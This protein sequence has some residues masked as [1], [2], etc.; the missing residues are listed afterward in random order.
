MIELSTPRRAVHPHGSANCVHN[1]LVHSYRKKMTRTTTERA[2]LQLRRSPSTYPS[3]TRG[4]HSHSRIQVLRFDHPHVL[5]RHG[6]R[7][8]PQVSGRPVHWLSR[9]QLVTE[10]LQHSIH[11]SDRISGLPLAL[12]LHK[13][14]LIMVVSSSIGS[15]AAK[16]LFLSACLPVIGVHFMVVFVSNQLIQDENSHCR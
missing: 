14:P 13:K 7:N 16:D 3:K 12:L 5:A 6:M 1:V 8:A 15:V 9:L 10:C 4:Y 11:K 2:D